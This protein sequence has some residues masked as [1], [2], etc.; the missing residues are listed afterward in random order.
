[1]LQCVRFFWSG[2]KCQLTM[3]RLASSLLE[4]LF[5][6][7][8]RG[9]TVVS[10]FL[11]GI[12]GVEVQ[13]QVH[14]FNECS[15]IH[16]MGESYSRKMEWDSDRSKEKIEAPI[17]RYDQDLATSWIRTN[18][19]KIHKLT[20]QRITEI[21]RLLVTRFTKKATSGPAPP[22]ILESCRLSFSF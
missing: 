6:R 3:L 17:Y 18:T 9:I 11:G 1:M 14:S 8:S 20:F 12:A 7:V 5:K 22:F 19:Q 15:F 10:D 13:R 16:H 21:S 4:S 2:V